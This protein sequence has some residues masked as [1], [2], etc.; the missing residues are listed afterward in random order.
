MKNMKITMNNYHSVFSRKMTDFIGEK[1]FFIDA[2]VDKHSSFSMKQKLLA[3]GLTVEKF[4]DK[5]IC[6]SCQSESASLRSTPPPPPVAKN[7]EAVPK[8]FLLLDH[9]Q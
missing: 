9:Y 6:I 7:V 3:F 2:I 5:G 4:L 1:R 8:I